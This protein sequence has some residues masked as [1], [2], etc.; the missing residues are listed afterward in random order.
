VVS[1]VL[2]VDDHPVFCAAMLMVVEAAEPGTQV[3]SVADLAAAEVVVRKQGFDLILLDMALPDVQGMSGLLLLRQLQPAAPIAIVSARDDA[4]L[5]R[6]SA[7]CGARGFIPKSMPIELMVN[8]VKVFLAG[9]QWF[10][11]GTF[12]T[13]ISAE[14]RAFA[15]RFRQLSSAQLRILRAIAD[16]RMNKQIAHDLGIAETTVKS[17]LQ[18]IFRKLGVANRMQAVIALNSFDLIPEA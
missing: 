1:F 17:H 3:K 8:A 11:E 10:P 12:A 6:R 4:Q 16:G 9:G 18:A 13:D 7:E 5:V 15:A 2:V 14:E